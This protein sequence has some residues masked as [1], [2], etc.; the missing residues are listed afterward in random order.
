MQL[1]V[2]CN[3]TADRVKNGSVN[4]NKLLDQVLN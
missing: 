4:V 2:G 1:A 3:N